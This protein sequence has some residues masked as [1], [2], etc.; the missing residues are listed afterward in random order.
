MTNSTLKKKFITILNLL[1]V[2]FSF[3]QNIVVKYNERSIISDERLNELPEEIRIERTRKKNYN[4]LVDT[5]NGIT[6]YSNDIETKNTTISYEEKN[7]S[8]NED[9]TE[10]INTKT[11]VNIRNTEKFY[12]KD[13]KNNIMLFEFFNG[14]Q[15]FHGKDSLQNW[16]WKITEEEKT[17]EGYT[18]TKAVSNWFGYEFTAWF[19]EE[20]PVNAGPE[21]F[22]GLPGLIL[23]VGTP[24]YEYKVVS[25]KENKKN[26]EI[27][28]P[29]FK[30]NKTY[31][32][33]EI[34]EIMNQKIKNL[35][36]STSIKQDGNTTIKKSTTI[37]SGNGK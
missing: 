5:N 13:L 6:Y 33:N 21:K 14:D 20:I 11:N 1:V 35:R 4:L 12:Y 31:T 23:Y 19:T 22:D 9:Y 16:D 3:S 10:I 2:T 34:N 37:Y 7:E 8:Q 36:P 27:Q 29:N 30:D 18:C 32:L 15:L 28:A 26:T 25:I 24:Y 17:I